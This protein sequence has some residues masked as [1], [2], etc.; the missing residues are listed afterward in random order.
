MNE[1]NTQLVALDER[2]GTDISSARSFED[3]MNIAGFDF[4]VEKVEV[5]DPEGTPVNGHFI[6]RRTDTN[7]PFACMRKRYNVVPMEEMLEPFHRMVTDHG[8]QY[9]NA[10]LIQNGR[11]CWIAA[12][13]PDDWNLKNR[14][15]DKLN[16]RIMALLSNDGTS[17][18]AYFSIANRVFC[19]NQLH[20]IQKEAN[21][22]QFGIR[23]TKN[24]KSRLEEAK[25]AFFL[26]IENL[27]EFQKVA[28]NL[29]KK[30]I[31]VNQ[32]RGFTNLLF[33]DPVRKEGEEKKE[34]S[35]KLLNRREAVVH[36][37]TNG[38]GNRGAS[39]W[40]ALN[41][42][43]EFLQHHNGANRLE[44]HGRKA[45]ERQLVS[46]LMGGPNDILT[47]RA[48]NML[49]TEKRFENVLEPVEASVS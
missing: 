28:N 31:T 39:R 3:V 35:R 13:F 4:D 49:A 18:N 41:A 11:K 17:L 12:R 22:S 16:N 32:V 15:D 20:Y 19:N 33:P 48:V 29:E 25:F 45:A 7:F 44:K 24:W 46:N 10:G 26:A 2:V 40:D 37:F 27:K 43:T 36:L 47:R 8:L 9:E 23:H 38:K 30:Q 34:V 21:K 14:P 5:H 1:L 42:V 6:I